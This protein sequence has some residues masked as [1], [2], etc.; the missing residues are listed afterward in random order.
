MLHAMPFGS[1]L[2]RVVTLTIR[3]FGSP[4]AFF[5]LDEASKETILLPGAEVPAGA[6]IG[7]AL[8]AFVYL[9]SEDRPVATLRTPILALGEVTFLTVTDVTKIGAFFDWG[10]PKE[11]LVPHAEQ[12]RSLAVGDRH[13]IGLFLDDT[14]RLAGTMRVTEMLKGPSEIDIEQGI[15]TDG[16]AW[17]NE[18]ELGLFVIVE[19]SFVGLVPKSEPHTASRGDALRVR[20]ANVL[21]D[22][23]IELSLRGAAHE[24]LA[25]DAE[26][27]LAKLATPNAPRIG[28]H[29]SPETIAAAFGLSKK[30]FKRAVGRLLKDHAVTIDAER[31][32]V[33]AGA[34]PGK[35]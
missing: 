23:K 20:V 12:T 26:R 2:G 18:P 15:W 8:E 6:Q 5:A 34:A 22:G 30:A 31:C 13:P 35:R 1:V 21:P 28:D 14:S 9:D 25:G 4:G 27:I 33:L 29:S 19:R 24:E 17:R 16:E 11:L 7:D 10:M 32:L 3:R